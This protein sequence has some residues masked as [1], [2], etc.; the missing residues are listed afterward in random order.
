MVDAMLDAA[1]AASTLSDGVEAVDIVWH[2]RRPQPARSTSPPWPPSSSPAPACRCASTATGRPRPSAARS[3]C[4]RR[5][6]SPS[7]SGPSGVAPASRPASGSALRP[8][9]TR[10]CATPGRPATSWASRPPSTSSARS[11]TRPVSG[12]RSSGWP[13]PSVAEQHAAASCRPPARVRALVVHGDDGLDELTTTDHERRVRAAATARSRRYEVDPTSFGLAQAEPDDL[14]GGT[15]DVNAD[16]GP[17]GAGRGP[18]SPPGH[19]RAQ[20]RRRLPGRRRARPTWPKALRW[21]KPPSTTAAPQ[22]SW[23]RWSRSAPAS[24]PTDAEL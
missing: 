20:R 9:S 13:T 19:R 1:D 23:P 8:A 5:S 11:P 21:P 14:L 18:R 4:S 2:R 15:A 12:A 7:I 6:A 24:P 16:A 17:S 3:T 10:R 22:P